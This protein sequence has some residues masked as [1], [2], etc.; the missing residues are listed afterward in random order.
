VCGGGN[1]NFP[2]DKKFVDGGVIVVHRGPKT[3][4]CLGPPY[5]TERAWA[6]R[7]S[8][9]WGGGGG[10]A[11]VLSA[12]KFARKKDYKALISSHLVFTWRYQDKW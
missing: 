1:E 7:I 11:L 8:D 2:G 6:A 5:F 12:G 10:G 3:I 9:G 4:I